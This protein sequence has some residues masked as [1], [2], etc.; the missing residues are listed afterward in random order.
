MKAILIVLFLITGQLAYTQS[1]V[2]SG[3]RHFSLGEYDEALVDFENADAIKS[4]ITQTAVA[5]IHYYRGMIWLSKAE[6]ASG[7]FTEV[8]P[9]QFGLY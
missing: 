3:I 5:K 4:M 9:L 8:D 2:D 1:Y 6:K 7:N